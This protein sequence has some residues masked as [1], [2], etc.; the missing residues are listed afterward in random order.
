MPVEPSQIGETLGGLLT[1]AWLLPLAGFA[2]EV[3]GGFWGTRKSKLAAYTAVGCIGVAFLCSAAAL[4]T[5]GDATGWA[6][7]GDHGGGHGESHDAAGST[8]AK[9]DH[10]ALSFSGTIY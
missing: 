10:A 1:F 7:L 8:H 4:Y 3:F 9:N 5:W 2:F 6:A